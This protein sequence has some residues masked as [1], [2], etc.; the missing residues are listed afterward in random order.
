MSQRICNSQ[1]EP[2]WWKPG[3]HPV[4]L[5]DI[6]HRASRPRYEADT[7]MA[8]IAMFLRAKASGQERERELSKRGRAQQRMEAVSRSRGSKRGG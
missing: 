4:H 8:G 6:K 2:Y 3:W 7:F 5:R 1:S